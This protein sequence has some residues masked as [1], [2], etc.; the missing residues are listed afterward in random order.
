MQSTKISRVSVALC[1]AVPWR[2]APQ[3]TSSAAVTDRELVVVGGGV[4]G[5]TCAFEA[6]A[7]GWRTTIIDRDPGHGAGWAAAGMLA[8]TAEA[9]FGEEALVRLLVAGAQAWPTFARDLARQSQI[10]IGFEPTGTILVAK[11]GGDR[12]ELR[13]IIELQRSLDLAVEDLRADDLREMEPSLSPALAGGALLPGDHQVSNRQLLAALMDANEAL[14]VTFLRDE[15]IRASWGSQSATVDLAS[16]RTLRTG[17][18]LLCLGARTSLIEAAIG[19]L[20]T[21]RPVKGHIL[22]LRSDEPLLGRTIRATVRGRSVYLVPRRDGELVVG[23]TVEE[24]GFDERIQAGEVF[25]LLDDA[26]RILPG[27][28]ELELVDVSCG[29]RPATSTNAPMIERIDDGPVLVATGHYRN[30]ILLA[31]LTARIIISELEG[32]PDPASALASAAGS[33]GDHR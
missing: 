28:D 29:L 20:P 33:R 17:A 9:H 2:G 30:G 27:V 31:P 23:A 18:L 24:R 3:V 21:V 6:A 15:A 16:G 10:D 25:S 22:R 1:Q 26:R 32:T 19:H 13:R 8:P 12:A 5:L 14:D 7:N 4:I 11:D